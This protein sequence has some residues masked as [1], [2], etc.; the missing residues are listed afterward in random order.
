MTS[1]HLNAKPGDFAELLLL[2]GDPKRARH[3][4]TTLLVDAREVNDVRNMLG[5]TGLWKGQRV[6]VMGSGIGIPTAMLYAQELIRDHGVK[7]I[8][9]VGTCGAIRRD[10]AIGD[11]VIAMGASTDSRVNRLRFRDLDFSA[12]ASWSLLEPVAALAAS[13]GQNLR[14]GNIF[15]SDFFYHPDKSLVALLE[16]FGVLGIDMESAGLYGVAAELGAEALGVLTVSDHITL[17]GEMS[18]EQRETGVDA[19]VKLVLDAL[20]KG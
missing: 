8:V 1:P 13:R 9:R 6:S 19:M 16:R 12:T 7:R 11:L 10:V 3:I 5:Y 17:G 20:L 2:P 15:S 18:A 14:V 4:A